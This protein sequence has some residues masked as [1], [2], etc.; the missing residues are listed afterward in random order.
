MQNCNEYKTKTKLVNYEK[1][2]KS[3]SLRVDRIIPSSRQKAL[4]TMMFLKCSELEYTTID[5]SCF[6]CLGFGNTKVIK[7]NLVEHWR[8][9]SIKC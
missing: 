7:I 6:L 3:I 2:N 1:R 5:V 4:N 8:L 9:E